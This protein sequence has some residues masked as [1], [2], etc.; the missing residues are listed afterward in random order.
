MPENMPEIT[1]KVIDSYCHN[2]TYYENSFLENVLKIA[3]EFSPQAGMSSNRLSGGLLRTLT[4]IKQ[5]QH[6]LEVG[7]FFGYSTLCMA[8]G[9]PQAKI[10]ALEWDGR[11][12]ELAKDSFDAHP[13][14]NTITVVQ[15]DALETIVQQMQRHQFDFI[16]IDADKQSYV[17]YVQHAI[18]H[19]P[20]GG[21]LVVDNTLW[22]GRVTDMNTHDDVHTK[23]ID[24]ANKMLLEHPN[25]INTLIPMRDGIHVAVKI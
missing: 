17:F 12:V 18:N 7:V 14:T 16:F 15:G 2:H 1:G 11:Y 6:I 9:A 19:L 23:A 21:V 5:P 20:S 4:A 8:E 25:M 3:Q 10:T 24:S 13:C 22:G